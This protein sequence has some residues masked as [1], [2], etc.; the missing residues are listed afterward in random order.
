MSAFK[1]CK[2]KDVLLELLNQRPD[3]NIQDV[4]GLSIAMYAFEFCKDKDVLLELLNQKPDLTIK[5][6]YNKTA[7]DYALEFYAK[8]PQFKF[9]VLEKL[10]DDNYKQNTQLFNS[11]YLKLR[12][13]YKIFPLILFRYHK[14]YKS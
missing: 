1:F 4:R 8:S 10:Y 6:I 14:R 3:L 12:T 5:D 11:E 13:K 2:I 7:L 9:D